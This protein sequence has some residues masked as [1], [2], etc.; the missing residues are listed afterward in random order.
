[1]NVNKCTFNLIFKDFFKFFAQSV[2][3]SVN[4]CQRAI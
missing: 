4:D 3:L 1:M 2:Y